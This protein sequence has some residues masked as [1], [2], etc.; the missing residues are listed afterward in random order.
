MSKLKYKLFVTD[1]DGTLT[2]GSYFISN[3]QASCVIKSFNTKDF[4]GLFKL[5]QQGVFVV[6][7]TGSEDDCIYS[8]FNRLPKEAVQKMFIYSGVKD[9]LEKLKFICDKWDIELKEVAYIGDDENDLDVM[10]EVFKEG[11][12][13]ATPKD[14]SLSYHTDKVCTHIS[15]CEGGKGA[16]RKF[17]DIV[18]VEN[19]TV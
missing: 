3:D 11:G 10:T 1:L 16:V 19:G 18:Y 17:A 12:I 13:T 2:D 9:K 8:Q 5:Q 6:I 7:L 15:D 4:H 14:S